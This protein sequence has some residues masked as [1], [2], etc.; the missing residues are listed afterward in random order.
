MNVASDH[1]LVTAEIK[2]KF[3]RSGPPAEVIPLFDVNI[4]ED[5]ALKKT[6]IQLHN[7]FQTLADEMDKDYVVDNVQEDIAVD[8]ETQWRNEVSVHGVQRDDHWL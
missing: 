5:N 6:F 4:L 8:I 3:K 2:L 7:R 1:H